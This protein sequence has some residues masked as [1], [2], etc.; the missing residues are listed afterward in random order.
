MNLQELRKRRGEIADAVAEMLKGGITDENREDFDKLRAEAKTI[1]ADIERLE[2]FEAE[3][4]HL[5]QPV[6]TNVPTPGIVVGDAPE[7]RSF[8]SFGEQLSA[9]HRAAVTGNRDPR[10]AE[11]R[12]VSGHSEG[13]PADGGFLV[14]SDFAAGIFQHAHDIGVFFPR[15]RRT[16]VQGNGLTINVVDESSRVAGS[17]WGG[18]LAYWK[19][20]AAVSYTHLTLPTILLV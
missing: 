20:E 4:R 19:P 17:R 6:S 9:V 14:Q 15:C 8:E 16:P 12:A 10:L 18:V 3:Q 2:E 1:A 11:E 5:A 13:V 7:D